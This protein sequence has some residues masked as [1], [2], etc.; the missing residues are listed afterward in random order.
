MEWRLKAAAFRLFD[1]PG[2]KHVHY[3]VQRHV[4]K[5][6]PRR[7]TTLESLRK[8][9]GRIVEDYETYVGGMPGSVIEVGAGRDLAVPLAL[10]VLG[11]G[12]VIASDVTRL[13]KLDLIR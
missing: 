12:K 3:F 9:A 7:A 2:G 8:I 11:V 6:W 1:L 5:N 10:R 13:A 4:T